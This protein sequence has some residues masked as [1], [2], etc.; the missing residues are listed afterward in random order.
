MIMMAMM[1]ML[2]IRLV[3][4]IL[5]RVTQYVKLSS[6]LVKAGK[7]ITKKEWKPRNTCTIRQRVFNY[8]IAPHVVHKSVEFSGVGSLTHQ[9]IINTHCAGALF[10]IQNLACS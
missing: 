1:T 5:K 4:L 2:I 3:L 7:K 9:V 8:P 6:C 10:T